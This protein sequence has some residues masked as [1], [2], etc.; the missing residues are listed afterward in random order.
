MSSSTK[1][2]K[3]TIY[4]GAD[5]V[6]PITLRYEESLAPVNLTGATEIKVLFKKQDLT[7]LELSLTGTQVAIVDATAGKIAATFDETTSLELYEGDDQAIEIEVAIGTNTLIT[8]VMRAI[9][10]KPRLFP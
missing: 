7:G 8:Q 5:Q 9:C 10:V 3:V 1:K 2:N 4:K 6:I